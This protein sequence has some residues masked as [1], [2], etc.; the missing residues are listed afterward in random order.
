M[1]SNKVNIYKP[2]PHLTVSVVYIPSAEKEE[3]SQIELYEI[4]FIKYFFTTPLYHSLISKSGA[5]YFRE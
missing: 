1:K 2:G 5:A 3:N 4:Q